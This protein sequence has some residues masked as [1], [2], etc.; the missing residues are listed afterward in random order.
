MYSYVFKRVHMY[1][2]ICIYVYIYIYHLFICLYVLVYVH[3]S[4]AFKHR[5]FFR[6]VGLY[7]SSVRHPSHFR[8]QPPNIQGLQLFRSGKR[9]LTVDDLHP[10]LL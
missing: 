9:R 4:C 8:L 7:I 1:S 3:I 5:C 10:A 2:L 6:L